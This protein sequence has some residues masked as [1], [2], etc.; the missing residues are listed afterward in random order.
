MV[1]QVL[2]L[3]YIFR[4]EPGSLLEVEEI[5]LDLEKLSSSHGEIS[6]ELPV[7]IT[8]EAFGDKP[9]GRAGGLPQLLAKIEIRLK[10]R[11]G[12]NC[13]NALTQ[14]RCELPSP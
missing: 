12:T 5:V 6:P 14:F 8:S 10:W 3:L 11:L 13:H 4:R 9:R 1:G 2:Q 7:A